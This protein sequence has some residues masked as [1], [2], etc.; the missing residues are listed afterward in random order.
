MSD[1]FIGQEVE[2]EN[3]VVENRQEK[4]GT[5]EVPIKIGKQLVESRSKFCAALSDELVSEIMG[6]DFS[7]DEIKN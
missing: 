4:G 7:E 1:I 3:L 5:T 6:M 2:I